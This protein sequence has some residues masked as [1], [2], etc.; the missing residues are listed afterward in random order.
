MLTTVL[1]P[2]THQIELHIATPLSEW[3]GKWTHVEVWRSVLGE[4][5]PYEPLFSHTELPARVPV[6]GGDRTTLD[7]DTVD[8]TGKTLSLKI[9]QTPWE[10]AYPGPYPMTVKALA[11]QLELALPVRAWVDSDRRLVLETIQVGG[12]ALLEVLPSEAA[13]LLG[14]PTSSPSNISAGKRRPYALDPMEQELVVADPFGDDSYF[15]QSRYTDGALVSSW[16]VPV[17][18]LT[19]RREV[20]A[21]NLAVGYVRLFQAGVPTAGRRVVVHP[22][23]TP[24][25]EADWAEIQL[26]LE[27]LTDGD[28]RVEFQLMRGR[29]YDVSISGTGSIRRVRIPMTG[30]GPYYLLGPELAVDDGMSI[31]KL[32]IGYADRRNP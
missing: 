1:S 26:P 17:S 8:L 24:A 6:Y 16:S 19:S 21:S 28:G 3:Q 5:G 23:R 13:T 15:Y 30:S 27:G 25:P 11:V 20:P 31:H 29:T 12:T 2:S 10:F 32:D 4:G 22:V 9:G 14:L 7:G 18:G